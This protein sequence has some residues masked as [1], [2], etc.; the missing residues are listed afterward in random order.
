MRWVKKY[1]N[2]GEIKR[3]NNKQVLYKIIKPDKV[4]LER[5]K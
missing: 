4:L 1:N 2:D 3:Y 5:N